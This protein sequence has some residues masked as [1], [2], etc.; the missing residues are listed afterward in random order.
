M[1]RIKWG[2]NFLEMNEEILDKYQ[3]SKTSDEIKEVEAE[4]K[5]E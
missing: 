4:I 5:A 2:H 1:E 3:K